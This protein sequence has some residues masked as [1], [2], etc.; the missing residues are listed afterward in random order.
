[1]IDKKTTLLVSKKLGGSIIAR[2]VLY[3]SRQSTITPLKR[4]PG[5][6]VWAVTFLFIGSAIW[7]LLSRTNERQAILNQGVV[8]ISPNSLLVCQVPRS[9]TSRAWL[10]EYAIDCSIGVLNSI[11]TGDIPARPE[12]LVANVNCAV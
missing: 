4:S 3:H 6:G 8:L 9:S 5:H 10:M 7:S 1:M 12:S 11:R 2:K